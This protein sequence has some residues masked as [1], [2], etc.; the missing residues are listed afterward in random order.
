MEKSA[1]HDAG[2]SV[3]WLRPSRDLS[4]YVSGFVERVDSDVF[5]QS[6]ELPVGTPF[7]HAV[8]GADYAFAREGTFAPMP[9]LSLW[10]FVERSRVTRPAGRLHAFVAA[11][12]YRGAALLAPPTETRGICLDLLSVLGDEAQTLMQ[13][14]H[15]AGSFPERCGLMESFIRERVANQ[16]ADRGQCVY[17]VA[18]AIV[19]GRLRGSVASIAARLDLHERTLRHQFRHHLAASPKML[20]RVA[21]L[22]RVIRAI[23][24]TPWGDAL[25]EDVTA[26][27][28]DD[29]HF[30]Q[31]FVSLTG[32]SPRQ[33]IQAKRLSGDPLVYCLANW[34]S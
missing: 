1:N 32:L 18:D 33:F 13:Q 27:F 17:D 28:F 4:L 2:M 23:H 15:M 6:L 34:P 3:R 11:L 14:L 29:A 26:E 7:L 21:R 12:T 16:R 22:N 24:P 25:P 31:E 30:H 19:A 9:A 10:G 5:G 20:L 8:L